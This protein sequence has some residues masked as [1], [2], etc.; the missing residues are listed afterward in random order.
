MK[1][2]AEWFEITFDE[3]KAFIGLYVLF[4]IKKLFVID[5]IGVVIYFLAF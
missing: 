2:D 3:M 5:F 4:G 1:L